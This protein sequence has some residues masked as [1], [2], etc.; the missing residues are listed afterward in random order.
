MPISARH[1]LPGQIEEI[2]LGYAMAGLLVRVG[3]NLME[4]APRSADDLKLRKDD[5]VSVV[6]K[7][8]EVVIQK[9]G[10]LTARPRFSKPSP[11]APNLPFFFHRG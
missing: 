3:D 5:I 2:R 11:V 6:A 4:R 10:L 7:A 1:K 8:A 9:E